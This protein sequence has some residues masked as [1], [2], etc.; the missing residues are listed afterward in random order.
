M[1]WRPN[2]LCYKDHHLNTVEF[3]IGQ[4]NNESL[5]EIFS[6]LERERDELYI[7]EYS[8]S[9][10]TLDQVSSLV[11]QL[12]D[13]SIDRLDSLFVNQLINQSAV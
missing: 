13:W 6:V 10:S 4:S 3:S 1:F 11:F 7:E 8:V 9:Q 2:G 5:A 12:L